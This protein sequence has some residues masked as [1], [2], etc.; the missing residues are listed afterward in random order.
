MGVSSLLIDSKVNRGDMK[1]LSQID[2]NWGHV[3]IGKTKRTIAEIGCLITS[4]SMISDYFGE[5]KT[6]DFIARNADFTSDGRLY[7]SSL[8]KI[9]R[10]F[11][12][13]GRGNGNNISV[14]SNHLANPDTAVI[15]QVR[16]KS[17]WVVAVRDPKY[18]N[19]FLVVD[20]LNGK[21][22]IAIGDFGNITGYATFKRA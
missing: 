1:Y 8:K 11:T 4:I 6:P 2:P 14:I 7:W 12:F 3:K 13:T 5:Y 20:S 16:N 22:R 10:K 19:D 17:H 18:S 9:F 21:T 15:L